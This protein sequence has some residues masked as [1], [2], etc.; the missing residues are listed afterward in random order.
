MYSHPRKVSLISGGGCTVLRVDLWRTNKSLSK[1]WWT[2]VN[3]LW[4]DFSSQFII[5]LNFPTA[6][7]ANAALFA[8]WVNL[9]LFSKW[10]NL[11]QTSSC[12]LFSHSSIIEYG[13]SQAS[14]YAEQ[15][16]DVTTLFQNLF[17]LSFV[18]H[19]VLSETRSN[20]S[21][22]RK[23]WWDSPRYALTWT[24]SE[25]I[26]YRKTHLNLPFHFHPLIPRLIVV[27]AKACH[28]RCCCVVVYY[29]VFSSYCRG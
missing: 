11:S 24:W 16:A 26:S 22:A 10:K 21:S 27:L 25:Q 14:N 12:A 8:G 28:T 23:S 20:K 17:S 18:L 29:F 1:M 5:S 7:P 9:S 6:A 4:R 2:F 19:G 15:C 13:Q 3:F